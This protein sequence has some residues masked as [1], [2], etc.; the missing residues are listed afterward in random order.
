M[1]PSSG[2]NTLRRLVRVTARAGRPHLDRVRVARDDRAVPPRRRAEQGEAR[3]AARVDFAG[4]RARSCAAEPIEAGAAPRP[5]RARRPGRSRARVPAAAQRSRRPP[6]LMSPR[7]TKAEGKRRRAPNTPSS[8]STYLPVATL[9][10]RT[11]SSVGP[12]RCRRAVA[13]R[14]AAAPR[15]ASRP[16]GCR[17]SAKRRRRARSTGSSARHSPSLVVMTRMPGTPGGGAAKAR[18]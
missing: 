9:P 11:T 4:R 10:S 6:R 5:R 18:A 17:S 7:P 1:S 12:E 16:G 13:R 3:A 8:G 2:Q 15:S 14:A